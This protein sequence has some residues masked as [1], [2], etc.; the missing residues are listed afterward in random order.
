M[1]PF[2][3]VLA[4]LAFSACAGPRAPGPFTPFPPVA[5]ENIV[6]TAP[7]ALV[8][9]RAHLIATADTSD[10]DMAAA[11]VNEQPGE[12]LVGFPYRIVEGRL[13]LPTGVGYRIS[14][15]TGQTF[16]VPGR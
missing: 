6:V 1:R 8:I 3:V 7:E 5:P 10:F 12:W 11:E 14:K 13:R 2:L 9:A 16:L 15:A 4:S